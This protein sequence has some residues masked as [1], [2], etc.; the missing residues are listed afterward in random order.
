VP[1]VELGD[2][3]VFSSTNPDLIVAMKKASAFVTD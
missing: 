1:K 2:I 3:L